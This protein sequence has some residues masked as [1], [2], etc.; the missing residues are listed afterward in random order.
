MFSRWSGWQKDKIQ[1]CAFRNY[2]LVLKSQSHTCYVRGRGGVGGG[3]SRELEIRSINFS[4]N[5]PCC[6]CR[7]WDDGVIDPVDTRTV[8]GLSLSAALNAPIGDPKFGVFRMWLEMLLITR[9]TLHRIYQQ[10]LHTVNPLLC[11][12]GIRVSP[13]IG[14]LIAGLSS[15]RTKHRGAFQCHRSC[16]VPMHTQYRGNF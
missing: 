11:R 2:T 7:L 9:L 6:C 5:L 4:F 16:R 15:L 10:C 12:T 8:L 13:N 3:G 1:F 14:S